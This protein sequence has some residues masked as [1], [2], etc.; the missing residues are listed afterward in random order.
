M[1][2]KLLEHPLSPMILFKNF[3]S[4]VGDE[5]KIVLLSYTIKKNVIN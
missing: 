2:G 5:H 4:P 3:K 1:H